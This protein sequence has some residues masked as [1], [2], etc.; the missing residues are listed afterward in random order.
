MDI[1]SGT[2]IAERFGVKSPKELGKDHPVWEELARACAF[3]L[4]NTL[5][6]WSPDR[7]VLGGSMFNDIGI[8]IERVSAHLR[9]INRAFPTMPDIAHSSL[10]SVGGL[11][12]GLAALQNLHQ[13]SVRV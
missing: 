6:H 3:A 8:S 1:F 9:D 13:E 4:Y 11:W 10:G 2:A 12:G 5:L 7:I